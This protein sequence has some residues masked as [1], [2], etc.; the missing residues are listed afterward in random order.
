MI[1]LPLFLLAVLSALGPAALHMVTPALPLLARAFDRP[2]GAVQLVLTLYLA[3]IA[4]GQL[5][6]GPVSDRFG[7]RPVMLWGLV[8]F[9]AGTLACGTAPSL[10]ILILGRVL[11]A[12][13]GC[14]GMVLGRAII[15]DVC[16]RDRAAGAIA[17]VTLATS[18]G[19]SVSPAVGAYLAE[20]LGWRAGFALL[21]LLGAAI[22]WLALARLGETNARPAALDIVGT[23]I[24]S[25][26]LLRSP[27]FVLLAVSSACTS[28]S[29]FTFIAITPYLLLD[30]LGRPPSTYG[31]MIL[32]PMLGY[33]I[34]AACAARLTERLG[35]RRMFVCGLLVSLA[36]GALLAV[37]TLGLGLSAWSM[38]VPM[39]LSSVGNGLSQPA[40]IAAGLS[41]YPRL[42]GSASGLMGFLQMLVAALGTLVIGHLP[43]QGGRWMAVVVGA[44]LLFAWL[45]GVLALRRQ[46]MAA[47]AGPAAAADEAAIGS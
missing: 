47:I 35:S 40:G 23:L 17:T 45:C 7:R 5:V 24:A 31:T 29:W 3:G 42:A 1:R 28:A 32:L 38:M 9:L 8:L 26:R 27:A 41:I 25:A 16:D 37:W 10:T 20:Y 4:L 13:G 39:A 11:Q 43:L 22:L 6:I 46:G 18:L 12:V 19:T 30:A 33:I 34:G 44:F 36:S 14:A 15:R 21:G 2:P